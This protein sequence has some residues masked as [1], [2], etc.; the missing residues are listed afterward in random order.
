MLLRG[1]PAL[2]LLCQL[3]SPRKSKPCYAPPFR[4]LDNQPALAR[5]LVTSG[6]PCSIQ[7]GHSYGPMHPTEIVRR[8]A[9]GT[10]AVVGAHKVVYRS[11]PGYVGADTFIYQI[12][13]ETTRGVPV[14]H[15]I[16]VA[17]QV[18]AK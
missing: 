15:K 4:T 9:H 12:R 8:P 3:H 11:R 17:V 16:G 14:V 18:T 10:L 2:S 7:L 1:L 5:M 6:E 13:G